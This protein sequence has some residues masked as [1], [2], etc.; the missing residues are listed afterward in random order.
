MVLKPEPESIFSGDLVYKF[1]RIMDKLVLVINLKRKSNAIKKNV[2]YHIDIM[3]LSAWL[4]VNPIMV[5]SYD[6]LNDGSDVK[7]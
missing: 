3:G 2:G 1:N 4:V 5:Y 7:L 6:F